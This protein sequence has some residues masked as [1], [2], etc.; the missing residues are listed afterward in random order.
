[1][2]ITPDFVFVHMP[3]TGGTFVVSVLKKLYPNAIELEKH[4]TCSDIPPQYAHLPIVSI[5]R[6]PFDRYVSQYF[7]GW[8]RRH[9][10][11]YCGNEHLARDRQDIEQL[12]FK[13]FIYLSDKYF[14]G[15]YQSRPNG[16]CN[17][18]AEQPLGWHTEQYFR[19][20]FRQPKT[21]FNRLTQGDIQSQAFMQQQYPLHVLFNE[22]LNQDLHRYLSTIGHS[23][24]DLAFIIDSA[25]ILPEG[26]KPR[27]Q[28]DWQ[29]YYDPETRAFVAQ[30][31]RILFALY[32]QYQEAA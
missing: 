13:D 7:Y 18:R 3:K 8:W 17:T 30:R 27:E 31:E 6:N 9:I 25:R 1:M 16:F 12:G 15:F 2:L 22:T 24:A 29:Q 21:L 20:F 28:R 5:L 19:F 11:L 26:G 4:G 32:P 10:E 23:A 14:K